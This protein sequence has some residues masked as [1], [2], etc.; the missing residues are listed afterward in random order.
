MSVRELLEAAQN[1]SAAEWL[2]AQIEARGWTITEMCRRMGVSPT[3]AARDVMHGKSRPAA[4]TI[5][6]IAEAFEVDPAV[7]SALYPKRGKDL[8]ETVI[9]PNKALEVFMGKPPVR[10][11]LTAKFSMA[12]EPGGTMRLVLDLPGV[13]PPDAFKLIDQLRLAGVFGAEQGGS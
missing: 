11:T 10:E 4:K 13:S 8:G 9:A 6:R 7:I 3:G 1:A 2:Q 12:L 5:R